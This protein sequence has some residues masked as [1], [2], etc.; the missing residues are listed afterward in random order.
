M[1]TP[2]SARSVQGPDQTPARPAFIRTSQLYPY[3][4][5]DRYEAPS[6]Q[7][8]LNPLQ[9]I[10]QK[11]THRVVFAVAVVVIAASIGSYLS[12]QSTNQSPLPDGLKLMSE[13]GI[14]KKQPWEV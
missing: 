5:I 2:R 14:K 8:K 13:N 7:R 11:S 9:R 6:Q 10:S 3:D 1:S 4:V 12:S